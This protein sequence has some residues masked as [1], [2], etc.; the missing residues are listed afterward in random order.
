MLSRD[1]WLAT[2]NGVFLSLLAFS[3]ELNMQQLVLL[4]GHHI[5]C[6]LSS[7]TV[8]HL[9]WKLATPSMPT[10]VPDQQLVLDRSLTS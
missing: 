8:V 10:F 6:V 1:I 5:L 7:V 2:R 9:P 4:R 3:S